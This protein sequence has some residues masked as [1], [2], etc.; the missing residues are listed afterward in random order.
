MKILFCEHKKEKRKKKKEK[1][2][3]KKKGY[4][5]ITGNFSSTLLNIL[6]YYRFALIL[7]V[8]RARKN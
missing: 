4:F 3:K 1:R 7:F 2:K 8:L 5:S 6:F